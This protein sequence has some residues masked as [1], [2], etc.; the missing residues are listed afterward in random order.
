MAYVA[1][2]HIHSRFAGACSPQLSIPNLAKWAKLKGVDLLG[3]GDALHPGWLPELKKYLQPSPT[4]FYTHDGV[5]FVISTEISCIYWEGS[6]NRR[7]H[8][9]IYLP[10]LNSAEKLANEMIKC[11]AKLG[12]DGR[13]IVGFSVKELC[14]IVWTTEPRSVIIPAHIWTP[15]FSLY[16]SKSGYDFLGEC[17]GEYSKQIYAVETGLSSEPAMNWRIADLDNKSIVSFSDLH[18]LPRLGREVT[19]FDGEFSY[20]GL[21]DALRSEKI[22]GTIEFFPEEGK[23]HYSGHRKCNVV[24]DSKQVLENGETCPVCKRPMTIGVIQRIEEL[25]TRTEEDLKLKKE[26]GITKSETF[27]QRPGFR[28]LV[29]LE[30]II[31]EALGQEVKTKKVQEKYETMVTTIDS[32]LK[33]LTKTPIDL[34]SMVAGERIARGVKKVR[35]GNIHIEP[36]YDNTYGKVSIWEDEEERDEIPLQ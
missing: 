32:E 15:W 29:Q 19:L 30:E 24:M 28:M 12:V 36:G 7:V 35:V 9:L 6:K 11:G 33:I 21:V 23:Y 8:I 22:I 4:G 17:F 18:S 26:N 16:G 31:A 10:S 34:I 20:D 13:P 5:R 1:D 14:N 3:S 25:A 2:L 27:P